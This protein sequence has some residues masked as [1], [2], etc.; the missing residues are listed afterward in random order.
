MEIDST[1]Y[2]ISGCSGS[3]DTIYDAFLFEI[4]RAIDKGDINIIKNAIKD[5]GNLLDKSYIE[6]ANSIAL[7]IVEEKIDS[8][9]I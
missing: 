2:D 6:W 5:F 9:Q 3:N 7:Q 4:D 8:M 1:I